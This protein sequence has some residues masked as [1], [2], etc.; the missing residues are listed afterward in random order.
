[1]QALGKRTQIEDL[2][3]HQQTF[4]SEHHMQ[5]MKIERT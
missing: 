3:S 2:Q 4:K 1:M 5:K